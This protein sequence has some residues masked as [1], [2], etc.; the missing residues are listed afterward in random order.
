MVGRSAAAAGHHIPYRN[1]ECVE[2]RC[3]AGAVTDDVSG[4][5]GCLTQHTSAEILLGVL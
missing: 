5:L 1:G 3:R 2:V 4:L